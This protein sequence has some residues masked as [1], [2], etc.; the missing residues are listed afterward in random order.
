MP[1]LRWVNQHTIIERDELAGGRPAG[2]SFIIS[3]DITQVYSID[4]CFYAFGSA[5]VWIGCSGAWAVLIVLNVSVICLDAIGP[6][7]DI[8]VAE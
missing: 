1:S 5:A 8:L 7:E 3:F 2:L 6:P 4:V